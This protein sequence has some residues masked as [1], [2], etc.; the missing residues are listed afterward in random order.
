MPDNAKPPLDSVRLNEDAARRLI[1]RAT[2]LDASLATE[3]SVAELREAARGA[4]IS[5]EAFHRALE[6]VRAEANAAPTAAARVGTFAPRKYLIVAAIA[7]LLGMALLVVR[8][9]AFP[10][11]GQLIEAVPAVPEEPATPVVPPPS[12][13]LPPPT[14]VPP[15][16]PPPRP[17]TKKPPE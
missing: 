3:S 6:E 15:A 8:S 9:R 4:G 7:L 16:S 10:V 2:E 14:P 12:A 1:Q 17:T 13:T 11:E 5:D